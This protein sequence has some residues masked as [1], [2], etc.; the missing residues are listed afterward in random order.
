MRKLTLLI[1]LATFSPLTAQSSSADLNEAARMEMERLRSLSANMELR[2][3]NRAPAEPAPINLAD[4]D[5]G[6]LEDRLS[7]RQAAPIRRP[8]VQEDHDLEGL[9]L[10]QFEQAPE[11]TNSPQNELRHRRLRGL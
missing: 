7:L 1:V 3:P 5:A 10:D 11:R 4:D 6:W 2:L 9:E 8:L